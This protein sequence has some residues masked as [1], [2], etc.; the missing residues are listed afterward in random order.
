M[1]LM[2]L[3]LLY[4]LVCIDEYWRVLGNAVDINGQF[5]IHATSND[6]FKVQQV[7]G[8][9][10]YDALELTFNPI[11]TTSILNIIYIDILS[12][13]A[14]KA[15]ASNEYTKYLI[16]KYIYIYIYIYIMMI[17]FMIMIWIIKLL[18]V[19]LIWRLI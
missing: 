12:S 10:L 5:K 11:D 9:A 16:Y 19:I 17:L 4:K 15:S 7:N 8:S 13:V 1:M 18:R 2:C 14:S 3:Y 6:K